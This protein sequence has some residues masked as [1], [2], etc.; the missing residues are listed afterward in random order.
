MPN[1]SAV[2]ASAVNAAASA[3]ASGPLA[4]RLT[5]TSDTRFGLRLALTSDTQPQR[6]FLGVRVTSVTTQRLPLSLPITSDTDSQIDLRL[7]LTS[8]TR[9]TALSLSLSLT[10]STSD[11]TLTPGQSRQVAPWATL[12]GVDVSDRLTGPWQVDR[13]A[14]RAAVA[15][16][17]LLPTAGALDAAALI[18]AAVQFGYT[19]DG[20]RDVLFTGVADEPAFD[21][22]TGLLTLRCSDGLQARLDALPRPIIAALIGGYWSA[23]LFDESVTG[24]EYAQQRLATQAA[25]YDLDPYGMGRLHQWAAAPTPHFTFVEDPALGNFLHATLSLANSRY[26]EQINRIDLAIE[27]RFQR[28]L[29]RART[30]RWQGKDFQEYL[31]DS[32]TLPTEDTIR[33]AAEATGWGVTYESFERLPGSG[34][35]YGFPWVHDPNTPPFFV[36][37]ATLGL[38]R[39][40]DQTITERYLYSITAP[41]SIARWGEQKSDDYASLSPEPPDAQAWLGKEFAPAGAFGLGGSSDLGGFATA[42]NG[43]LY[44]DDLPAGERETAIEAAVARARAQILAAHRQ[45]SVSL[46]APLLPQI[47]LT[48]TARVETPRLT[49]QG[50]VRQIIHSGSADMADGRGPQTTVVLALSL[51]GP[52]A[53]VDSPIVAPPRLETAPTGATGPALGSG[54]DTH[55]G[56]RGGE[57]AGP[58]TLPP[59][60]YVPSPPDDPSWVGWVGNYAL[61]IP[62]SAV[63]YDERFV[64][65]VGDIT[66]DPIEA[67]RALPHTVAVPHDE[68]LL[69]S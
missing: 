1:L 28:R 56:N 18:G 55:L 27:V 50:K 6:L 12:A 33:Q 52:E 34:I 10:S 9:D 51:A 45:H 4:L 43:D 23:A 3:A 21:P 24:Y 13:E 48:H 29:Q 38:A 40:W 8:E 35:Y 39:R 66:R 54:E 37:S 2:N 44:L 7:L 69:A 59:F 22:T 15:E 14:G 36:L 16:F 25:D 47:D 42:P 20:A 32:F 46:T 62:W 64:V 31:T 67:T 26:K 63:P 41:A 19:L 60:G 5:L 11:G 49:A 68:L 61:P 53:V 57:G 17:T 30:F 65:D 58:V